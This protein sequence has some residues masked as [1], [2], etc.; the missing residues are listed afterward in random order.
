MEFP[1]GLENG[2]VQQFIEVEA[3]KN[4][5]FSI[6]VAKVGEERGSSL[7]FVLLFYTAEGAFIQTGLHLFIHH[8]N[9][10]NASNEEWETLNGVTINTPANARKALLLVNKVPEVESTP[11]VITNCRISERKKEWISGIEVSK[12]AQSG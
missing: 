7:N 1:G 8:S 2:Y 5:E 10:R 11:V 12:N 3:G 4:Y 6:S 9:L